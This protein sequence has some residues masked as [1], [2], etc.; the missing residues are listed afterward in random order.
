M[1]HGQISQNLPERTGTG[2]ARVG[3]AHSHATASVCPALSCAILGAV[4]TDALRFCSGRSS[5][6]QA[7]RQAKRA[8]IQFVRAL[9]ASGHFII[10]ALTTP[11]TGWQV[12]PLCTRAQDDMSYEAASGEIIVEQ[13]KLF[14]ANADMSMAAAR[15]VADVPCCLFGTSCSRSLPEILKIT[16]KVAL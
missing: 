7:A 1:A 6:R 10:D 5:S 8:L 4:R 13:D 15:G 2:L 11:F 16:A 3:P 9:T 14:S 12:T